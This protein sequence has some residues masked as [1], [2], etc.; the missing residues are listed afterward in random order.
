MRNLVIFLVLVGFV[1]FHNVYAE[2]DKAILVP[3]E[4]SDVVLVGTVVEVTTTDKK[5]LYDFKVDEYLKGEKSFDLITATLDSTRPSDFPK[6]P[7][8]YFNKP[9]FEKDNQV[10]VYLKQE[11]STF[12]MSPYSFTI[13][14]PTVVGPPSIIHAT[15]PQEHIISQGDEIIISGTIKKSY[16]YSL[17]KSNLDSSFNLVVK[18]ENEEQVESKKLEINLDGSYSFVFQAKGELRIPG[19]YSWEI[20]F[21]NGGMGG[22]FIVNTDQKRW[23]PL[24]QFKSG[25]QFNQVKCKDNLVLIQKYDGSPACVKP[26]TKKKLVERGWVQNSSNEEDMFPST[27]ENQLIQ[28][29]FR[30]KI[31]E[32]HEGP[33]NYVVFSYSEDSGQTFSKPVRMSKYE[34]SSRE[35]KMILAG[36][37]VLLSWRDEVPNNDL[38][39]A[40]SK[41]NG[42][43][44]E[45][46][47]FAHGARPDLIFHDDI[48]YLT[49]VVLENHQVLYSTSKNLGTSFSEPL[50]VFMPTERFSPFALAPTPM[51]STR[52]GDVVINWEISGKNYTHVIGVDPT[53]PILPQNDLDCATTWNATATDD[54]DYFKLE[55]KIRN[56]IQELA[57]VYN[58]P[59]REIIIEEIN[60]NTV[61]I[62][63]HGCWEMHES[64]G[65]DLKNFLREIEEIVEISFFKDGLSRNN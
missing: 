46:K 27:S 55:K 34:I 10:F 31:D 17:E 2:L 5:T 16:L 26:E 63:I 45:K 35:P 6:D 8:D 30:Y 33:Y 49:W 41:D 58:L 24:K 44:F 62:I 12:Q 53:I 54:L 19:K 13:K 1:I 7:L 32:E 4:T 42:K 11:G 25:V 56:K 15:G 36:K 21:H 20:S 64:A 28:S 50:V 43:T 47:Y 59:D 14:K 65:P 60:K 48:L 18:N 29:Q 37:N 57:Q 38:A 9:F 39:F 61:Q 52:N 22:E 40:I 3:F 23:T 51:F